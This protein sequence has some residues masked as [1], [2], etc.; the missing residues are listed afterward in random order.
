M[1]MPFGQNRWKPSKNRK[2]IA[3]RVLILPDSRI[4]VFIIFHDIFSFVTQIIMDHMLRINLLIIAMTNWLA[5]NWM[6]DK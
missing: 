3:K 5:D 4:H 1:G 2:Q 6:D